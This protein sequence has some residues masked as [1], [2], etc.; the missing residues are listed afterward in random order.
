M[1]SSARFRYRDPS[2]DDRELTSVE[3]LSSEIEEGRLGPD[4]QLLDAGIGDWRRAGDLPIVQFIVDEL[5]REGRL[6]EGWEGADELE[7][8]DEDTTI[9]PDSEDDL[10]E[11][12][13][14]PDPFEMHL[15]ADVQDEPDERPDDRP[16]HEWM[17]DR[18]DS[19]D[20][21]PGADREKPALERKPPRPTDDPW[22]APRRGNRLADL[23]PIAPGGPP[24]ERPGEVDED[25]GDEAIP[26]EIRSRPPPPRKDGLG[27]MSERRGRRRGKVI[28]FLLLGGAILA[29]A[30]LLMPDGEEPILEPVVRPPGSEQVELDLPPFPVPA[31]VSDSERM[32]EL[33]TGELLSIIDSVRAEMG[34]EVVP[35]PGW[36][37]GRYLS[38]ASEFDDTEAFWHVYRDFVERL[39]AEDEQLYELAGRRAWAAEEGLDEPPASDPEMDAF[40]QDIRDRY[41]LL[42]EAREDGYD[43]R[44]RVAEEAIELH[45][46][47]VE[48]ENRIQY[49][50]ALGQGVSADPI[51]EAV[52]ADEP[53]RRALEAQL[54]RLF[55]ALDQT[56]SG[57]PPALGGLRTELFQRLASPI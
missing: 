25:P 32:A 54:D 47:L 4:T 29:T 6:P 24:D 38:S 56:R 50:P 41:E 39:A 51:L 27:R 44:V 37:G 43:R 5:R 35:P 52:P 8:A 16:L 48:Y 28:G 42:A 15:P 57:V 40:L 11:L 53:S 45:A 26:E 1:T 3:D 46:F 49:A 22:G 33:V 2:G 21:P 17:L 55:A 10:E 14:T 18:P 34:I 30:L 20:E 31:G 7:P 9:G 23:E 19:P 36:L 13:L 12:P